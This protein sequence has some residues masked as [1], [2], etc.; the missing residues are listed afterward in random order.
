MKADHDLSYLFTSH[1][2]EVVR[3]LCHGSI[4]MLKGNLVEAAPPQK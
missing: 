1:D 2:L 4:V 3:A